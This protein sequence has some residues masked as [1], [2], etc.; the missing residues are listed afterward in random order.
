MIGW[1]LCSKM[2]GFKC[3]QRRPSAFR[4]VEMASASPLLSSDVDTIARIPG[5]LFTLMR[6]GPEIYQFVITSGDETKY[7]NDVLSL[8]VYVRVMQRFLPKWK[9][10]VG[11]QE[12][13]TTKGLCLYLSIEQVADVHGLYTVQPVK[14]ENSESVMKM[15]LGLKPTDIEESMKRLENSGPGRLTLLVR[16]KGVQ[17]GTGPTVPAHTTVLVLADYLPDGKSRQ[18]AGEGEE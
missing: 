7:F 8:L 6:S 9:H 15:K 2:I 12:E 13:L 5:Q 1:L 11:L 14:I 3:R 16:A 17:P 18:P 4:T 10:W